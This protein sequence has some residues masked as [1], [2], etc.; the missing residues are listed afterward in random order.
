MQGP[1]TTP[2]KNFSLLLLLGFIW[3]TGYSIARFAM[4]HDV[5]PLGYSFW[6][7]LGP[8]IIIGFLTMAQDS[9]KFAHL[10]TKRSRFYLISGLTGIVIPNTSMYFAA[11]HL[12]ASILAMIVNTVPIIAYPLALFM[13]LERFNIWR[14]FGIGLAF[15]GLMLIIVPKSSLPSPDLIPWVLATLITPFSFA[16]CSIYIARFRPANTDSLTLSA[17]MLIFSSLMLIPMV[18]ITDSF[19]TFQIPFTAPDWVIILEILLSSIGYVL[20]FQLIKLAGPVYYS[21]VDT[22]VVITGIL[23]GYLIFGE[24]LN[25]FTGGAVICI[26]IALL[27]VTHEQRH[28]VLRRK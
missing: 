21:M 5:P 18:I 17:G 9:G 20:F 26:V 15:L 25:R 6:Q 19:Y 22:I 16:I 27:I 8:A 12:P 28:A 1:Q 23:W 24:Q 14:L 4:T 3:G 13:R 7:S 10:S 11:S 2:L